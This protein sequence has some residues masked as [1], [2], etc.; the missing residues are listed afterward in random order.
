MQ[1]FMASPSV[2]A[3]C[4]KLKKSGP[5][6]LR[7]AFYIPKIVNCFWSRALKS[8][9]RIAINLI[10]I[11]HKNAMEFIAIFTIFAI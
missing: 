7:A 8:I 2:S 11:Y 3:I 9:Y 10:A 5:D 1:D 6:L 4:S